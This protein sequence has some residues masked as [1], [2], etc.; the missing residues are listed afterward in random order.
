MKLMENKTKLRT[1]IITI[2]VATWLVYLNRLR[3]EK[4]LV[5][6]NLIYLYTRIF[7]LTIECFLGGLQNWLEIVW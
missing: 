1:M 5:I 6:K 7:P 4:K 2:F 3:I